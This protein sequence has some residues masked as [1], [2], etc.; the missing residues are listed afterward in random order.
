MMLDAA[1]F[2]FAL[3]LAYLDSESDGLPAMD[4]EPLPNWTGE[5]LLCATPDGGDC[6]DPS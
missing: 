1:R 6:E 3:L 5:A 2:H 4:L